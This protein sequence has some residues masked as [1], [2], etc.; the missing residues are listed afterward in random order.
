MMPVS[1]GYHEWVLEQL[2]RV[3]PVTARKM[4]G[5]VGIYHDGYFFALMDADTLYLKV[6]DQNRPDFEAVGAGPFRPYADRPEVMQYYPPPA[7]L[8][9][10]PEQLRP[11]IEK[12]I[13]VA[14]RARRKK[15]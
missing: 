11:W 6:D 13:D 1:E 15:R 8:L 7:E 14:R 2:G 4:F 9:D 10:D 3:V 12:A 5:G